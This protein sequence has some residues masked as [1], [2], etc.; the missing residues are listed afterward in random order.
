[1]FEE[2]AIAP[3]QGC[4]ENCDPNKPSVPPEPLYPSNL[5][6]EYPK[7]R[8]CP[9]FAVAG[10]AGGDEVFGVIYVIDALSPHL[11]LEPD[12]LR[13]FIYG[14]Q[15]INRKISY[16]DELS[17]VSTEKMPLYRR[18]VISEKGLAI[19]VAPGAKGVCDSESELVAATK[20]LQFF[21]GTLGDFACIYKVV[22]SMKVVFTKF[23]IESVR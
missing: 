1:M 10:P 15:M 3:I 23:F 9:F 4:K 2:Q 7:T 14:I 19:I 16:T 6:S 21:G 18:F 22:Y 13:G 17:A 12:G 5:S 8:F 20:G 11:F